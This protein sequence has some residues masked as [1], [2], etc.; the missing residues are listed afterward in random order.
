M[1]K[2]MNKITILTGLL[3]FAMRNTIVA[4]AALD[5]S[6]LMN[7]AKGFL[8]P[9]QRISLVLVP[10]FSAIYVAWEFFRYLK[11]K[12]EGENPKPFWTTISNVV[13]GA[14]LVE[15]FLIILGFFG[16]K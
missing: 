16:V 5:E 3:A 2:F 10:A 12:G 4:N 6:G 11:A 1:N 9:L 15:A 7:W 14:V 13:I 8:D